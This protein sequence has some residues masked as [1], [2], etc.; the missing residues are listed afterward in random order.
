[1]IESEDKKELIEVQLME[2]KKKILFHKGLLNSGSLGSLV[3]YDS[4]FFF[5]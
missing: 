2:L 3:I 5:L 1:M 4:F